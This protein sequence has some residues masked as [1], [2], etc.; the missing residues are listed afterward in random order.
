MSE[1]NFSG[2]IPEI[3][4]KLD[5]LRYLNFSHNVLTGHIPSSLGNMSFLESLDLSTNQLHGEIPRQLTSLTF[6][7]KL[8]LSMNNLVGQIP[9]SHQFSTFDNDS[10]IGNQG[11]CG[12]PLTKKCEEGQN[13]LSLPPQEDDDNEFGFFD[14]F[15]W[16][17]VALGYGCGFV[18]GVTAA[19]T[20]NSSII[21]Q[22]SLLSL[23]SHITSDPYNIL[24]NNWTSKTSVCSWIG[25]S[26]NSE[27]RVI[28]LNI[29]NMELG[30]TIPSEIG[31][32]SFL[33]SLD[34][35]ENS[36][37]GPIPPSIFTMPSLETLTLRNNSLSSGLPVDMCKHGLHTLKKLRIS[38]N[39]LYGVIPKS[40]D[41]CS[42]LEY[43]S[44]ST[45]N[46][47]GHV[48][49]QIGNLTGLHVL[50]LGN[51]THHIK[52]QVESRRF[53]QP[54]NPPRPLTLIRC[55]IFHPNSLP[56]VQAHTWTN[57]WI[58]AATRLIPGLTH[59]DK[60]RL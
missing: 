56:H 40:L 54:Y 47:S 5:S 19:S 28:E 36:F 26:C 8:N 4:G 10:Y 41:Q 20:T 33:I 16:Q 1:N 18:F 53:A 57:T 14:G 42:Q 44:L 31:N 48:P 43:T 24:S 21:D 49:R 17:V 7:A 9:Q 45:N 32:L 25:V 3:I 55:G 46:F 15:T 52:T 37:H 11:L 38:F 39:N 34:M 22:S 50:Y 27:N 51:I 58:N 13:P 29:S 6:L 59:R 60:R 35:S 23:K 30:G 2:S 12:F